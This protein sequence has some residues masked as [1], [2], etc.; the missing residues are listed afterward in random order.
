MGKYKRQKKLEGICLP[1]EDYIV[2][3]NKELKQIN[4]EYYLRII[5]LLA[6]KYKEEGN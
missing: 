3:I 4:T 6:K 1:K 5:Y 2:L